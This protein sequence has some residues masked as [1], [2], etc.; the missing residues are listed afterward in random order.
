MWENLFL[1]WKSG[2]HGEEG[3]LF[4]LSGDV[5]SIH[6]GFKKMRIFK[7]WIIFFGIFSEACAAEDKRVTQI[8]QMTQIFSSIIPYPQ[9]RPIRSDNADFP[10]STIHLLERDFFES[11]RL[12]L[13]KGSST[14]LTKPLFPQE[15][16]DVAGDA[17]ALP[18]FW[19][20]SGAC[21][22]KGWLRVLTQ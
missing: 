6:L 4:P 2:C 1:S 14:F 18:E 21:A 8:S 20:A 11:L 22:L 19:S 10:E 15:R 9:M 5:V 7:N 17:I 12:P 3:M 13:A 16:E